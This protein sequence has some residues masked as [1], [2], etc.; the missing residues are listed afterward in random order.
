MKK[1][2][3]EK[4]Y[5]ALKEMGFLNVE[6]LQFEVVGSKNYMPLVIKKIETN[7]E[8]DEIISFKI[9]M[10]QYELQN[11]ALMRNTEICIDIIPAVRFA[12]PYYFSNDLAGI[13]THRA[14]YKFMFRWLKNIKE[15]GYEAKEA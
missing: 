2:L 9:S 10:C 3:C 13:E 14:D 11:G 6:Y 12:A 1:D 5:N 4:L 7:K 15:A 8:N